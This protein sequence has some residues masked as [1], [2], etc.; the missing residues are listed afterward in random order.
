M[1]FPSPPEVPVRYTTHR[2]IRSW[3]HQ[4]HSKH[5]YRVRGNVTQNITVKTWLV[6]FTLPCVDLYYA[7]FVNL[8]FFFVYVDGRFSILLRIFRRGR[9][10]R[11]FM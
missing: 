3:T 1:H 2:R 5:L 4:V 9:G 6:V 7:V 8:C 11:E 10:V